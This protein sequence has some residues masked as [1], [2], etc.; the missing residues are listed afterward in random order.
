MSGFRWQ[1]LRLQRARGYI[2]QVVFI[3]I[4]EINVEEFGYV[5]L[6]PS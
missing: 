6:L 1:W 2:K 5:T 3:K 4:I